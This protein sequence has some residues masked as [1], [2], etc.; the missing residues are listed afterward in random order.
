MNS[1]DEEE[2]E[3]PEHISSSASYHTAF[4]RAIGQMDL[5]QIGG[6]HQ[7]NNKEVAYITRQQADAMGLAACATGVSRDG[8]NKDGQRVVHSTSTAHESPSHTSET[9]SEQPTALGSDMQIVSENQS[10]FSFNRNMDVVH[11]GGKIADLY[12]QLTARYKASKT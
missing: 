11:R 3:G 5:V 9:T 1:D 6:S 7:N 12:E 4:D 2:L 8:N 10:T